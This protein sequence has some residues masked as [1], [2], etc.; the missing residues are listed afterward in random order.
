M[1]ILWV[2]PSGPWPTTTPHHCAQY[3]EVSWCRA[4]V[5]QCRAT[6]I[7][8]KL[9]TLQALGHYSL[10]KSGQCAKRAPHDMAWDA[11]DSKLNTPSPLQ[12]KLVKRHQPAKAS[13]G[14]I[15]PADMATTTT[16]N[17]SRPH[18]HL[19][20]EH[21]FQGGYSPADPSSHPWA[22]MVTHHANPR[23]EPST[24]QAAAHH[25]PAC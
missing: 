23:L 25:P 16:T 10:S 2:W 11:L 19:W 4:Y 22:T 6:F 9:F 8:I 21:I 17:N 12:A 20:H 3:I 13:L 7:Q 5:C 15:R 18:P 24:S 1:A 14:Q